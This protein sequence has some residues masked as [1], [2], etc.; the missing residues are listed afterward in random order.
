MILPRE[1]WLNASP[2]CRDHLFATPLLADPAAGRSPKDKR[3]VR[4]ADSE[5][6][7]WWGQGSPN[8]PMDERAFILNRSRAVDYLNFL[9]SIFVVDGYANWDEEV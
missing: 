5:S 6:D 2:S 4:E 3:V 9:P 8:Y 1:G 7:I